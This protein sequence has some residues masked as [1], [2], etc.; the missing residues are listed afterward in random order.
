MQG[1][2][3]GPLILALAMTVALA[4]IPT[5]TLGRL[6]LGTLRLEILT[7]GTTTLVLTVETLTLE[8]L[9]LDTLTLDT[10][11][12]GIMT[13]ETLGTF[14]TLIVAP[15]VMALGTLALGLT[16]APTVM[17]RWISNGAAMAAAARARMMGTLDCILGSSGR[18]P[19]S[20][21]ERM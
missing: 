16:V 20:P 5:P 12:L 18:G 9:T 1:Y 19:K 21:D 13:L 7:L 17:S 15:T 14:G 4:L 3:L 10:L 2:L 6:T 11:M 8:T